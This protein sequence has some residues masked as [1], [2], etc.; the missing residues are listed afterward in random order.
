MHTPRFS[1]SPWPLQLPPALLCAALILRQA[2]DAQE[3]LGIEPLE[4]WGKGAAKSSVAGQVSLSPL[5]N[6][7][8][9]DASA[10]LC[11]SLMMYVAADAQEITRS[12]L[13]E[14]RGKGAAKLSDA[15]QVCTHHSLI[16]HLGVSSRLQP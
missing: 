12:E 6:R 5:L 15:G 11:P 3:I 4:P 13:L 9:P 14:S 10:T 1:C 2:A 7:A 8:S 16:A